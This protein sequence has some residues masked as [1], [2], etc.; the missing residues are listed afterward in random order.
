[1]GLEWPKGKAVGE[2][3]CCGTGVTMTSEHWGGFMIDKRRIMVM[4]MEKIGEI[5]LAS[6]KIMKMPK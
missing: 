6:S 1:M 3:R 5:E 4:G 2:W